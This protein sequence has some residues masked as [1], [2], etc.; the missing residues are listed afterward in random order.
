MPAFRTPSQ[1]HPS[2]ESYDK[3]QAIT[4]AAGRRTRDR[5]PHGLTTAQRADQKGTGYYAATAT[6]RDRLLRGPRSSLTGQGTG[7]TCRQP[8]EAGGTGHCGTMA[9]REQTADSRGQVVARQSGSA[10]GQ[11]VTKHP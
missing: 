5:L 4:P 9:R 11:A 6:Q 3:G 2:L 1:I 8:G 7:Y 10:K